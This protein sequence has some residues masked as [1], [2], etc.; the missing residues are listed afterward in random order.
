[1]KSYNEKE[2]DIFGWLFIEIWNKIKRDVFWMTGL[3]QK[4][5][6]RCYGNERGGDINMAIFVQMK[7]KTHTK[8]KQEKQI[9]RQLRHGSWFERGVV[10]DNSIMSVIAGIIRSDIC[11][12][13]TETRLSVLADS[14]QI[15][16]LSSNT[17]F[18]ATAPFR[19]TW[20]SPRKV[21]FPWNYC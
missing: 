6:S 5:W 14:R 21:S 7:K 4:V 3:V 20:N 19:V 13:V 2:S 18:T 12:P 9:G 17:S 11:L 16:L 8:A 1:M 15:T 10:F